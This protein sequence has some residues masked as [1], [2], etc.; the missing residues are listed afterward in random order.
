VVQD[1][2]EF[3]MERWDEVLKA[4]FVANVH[5]IIDSIIVPFEPTGN[6]I[7][8]KRAPEQQMRD[9]AFLQQFVGIYQFFDNPVVVTL[10]GEHI[11]SAAIIGQPDYELIPFQGTEF[12]A[13]G[14]SGVSIEFLRDASSVVTGAMVTLTYGVFHAARKK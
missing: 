3:V 13:K 2:F 12:L 10:K 4:S 8:F 14:R 6:D 11:L 5:G 9:K 1:I 7:V